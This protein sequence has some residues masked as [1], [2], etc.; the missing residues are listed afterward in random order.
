[1]NRHHLF[2]SLFGSLLTLAAFTSVTKNAAAEPWID[3]PISLPTLHASADLG[4]GFG[5]TTTVDSNGKTGS[6]WGSGSNIEAAVGLPIL[7]EVGV[8]TGLRFGDNGKASH[9]DEY[10]RLFDKETNSTSAG[11]DS[12]ANPEIYLRGTLLS[13]ELV[14]VGLETRF[15][16]PAADGSHFGWTPGVP[17]RIHLPHM[18]RIDTGVYVPITF[19]DDTFYNVDIPAALWFQFDDLFVGPIA[20]LRFNHIPHGDLT[21]D[22]NHADLRLGVGGGYTVAGFIDLKAQL[23]AASVNHAPGNASWT[24]TIGFGF[25]VGIR[26]P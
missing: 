24:D 12:V 2:G 8:R 14:E 26:V 4:L 18:A 20:G 6:S 19:G 21:G 10:G 16:I 3:R 11:N 23:Y 1:M 5:Q 9:A 25:G 7:G 22:D 17:V 15:T 13:L